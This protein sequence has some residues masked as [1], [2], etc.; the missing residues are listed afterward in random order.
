MA[1]GHAFVDGAAGRLNDAARGWRE[2]A[3][4][5]S[6]KAPM[7]RYSAGE[8]ALLTMDREGAY[9]DLVAI[10]A[11]GLP[12]PGIDLRRQ[13]LH[14]GL[15]ALE[16]RRDEAASRFAL[17]LDALRDLGLPFAAAT[18]TITMA[19]V[20]GPDRAEVQAAHGEARDTLARLGAKP[21]LDRLEAAM[22]RPAPPAPEPARTRDAST[23]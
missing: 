9:S 1:D 21:F 5:F 14:A 2:A 16:G 12:L 23:V 10:D 6:W 8:L 3:Q 19:T 13:A 20:L 7:F 22:V 4:R 17:V 11:A 15:A 18:L